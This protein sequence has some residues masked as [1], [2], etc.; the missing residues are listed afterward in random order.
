VCNQGTHSCDTC[1]GNNDNLTALRPCPTT[2]QP[3]CL[4]NGACGQC[5]ATDLIL[6]NGSTPTC[7]LTTHTCAPCNGDFGTSATQA[8]PTS[9]NPFCH[10]SGPNQG[11]CGKC[12]TNGDC[13]GD[14]AGSLCNTTSGSCG[15]FCSSDGDCTS[16]QWCALGV[17]TAKTPNGQPIPN[18]SGTGVSGVCTAAIGTRVC[19]AGACETSDNLCGLRNGD[20]CGPPPNNAECRSG[21]C[22]PG[23]NNCGQ[24]PGGP[25]L[26]GSDCQSGICSPNG[27]CGGCTNDSDCGSTTSGR[28]CDDLTKVCENGCRGAGGNGC[29][30]TQV[31][32]S[33]NQ[34]IGTCGNPPPDAGPPDSGPPDSGTPDSGTHDSGVDSG[35]QDSGV[36]DSG[37]TDSGGGKDS[38]AE[39]ASGDATVTD[40][41]NGQDTGAPVVVGDAAPNDPGTVEGGGCSCNEAGQTP[42]SMAGWG[43]LVGLVGLFHARRPKKRAN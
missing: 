28:V 11:E 27:T 10:T 15:I 6:C 39:D 5:S 36:Q 19:L 17:C 38:G 26:S 30:V 9:N 8:C 25:C 31:C 2:T 37:P 24:P 14:P 3:A 18:I 16:T 7:D 13:T 33:V 40:S 35:P 20:P 41:G 29:P 43:V 23:T 4:G 42:S 22:D 1:T 32:S 12:T 34:Q 21:F